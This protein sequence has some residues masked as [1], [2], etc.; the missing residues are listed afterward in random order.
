VGV[1]DFERMMLHEPEAM[2]ISTGFS[3]M[4]K[5]DIKIHDEAKKAKV[6]L[7]ALPTPEAIKKY[8]ELVK[9]GKKVVARIHVTC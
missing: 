7:Y 1:K 6:D 2:I 5:I 9:A 3:N 4:V 8:E